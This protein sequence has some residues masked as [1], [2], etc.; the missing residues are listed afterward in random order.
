MLSAALAPCGCPACAAGVPFARCSVRVWALCRLPSL[1]CTFAS[2]AA[3]FRVAPHRNR[4]SRHPAAILPHERCGV[5]RAVD[6]AAG[7]PRPFGGH[8][9]SA[10][11]LNASS[12]FRTPEL[13]NFRTFRPVRT[14]DHSSTAPTGVKIR[15]VRSAISAGWASPHQYVNIDE[16]LE[17]ALPRDGAQR[18]DNAALRRSISAL[19]GR[20]S[21]NRTTTP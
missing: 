1:G 18:R 20:R 3:D 7:A 8:P 16:D 12:N 17:G 11:A 10:R 2:L 9:P 13:S 6:V 19:A 15:D 4:F 5:G 21:S 14:H